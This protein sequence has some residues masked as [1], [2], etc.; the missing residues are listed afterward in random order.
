MEPVS[1]FFAHYYISLLISLAVIA[2]ALGT[3]WLIRRILF[4]LIGT[5]TKGTGSH[6]DVFL[7]D[8]LRAPLLIW[9]LML[10]LDLAVR[11]SEVPVKIADR[12][13]VALAIL[14]I[15]SLTLMMSRLAG[16]LV[17]FYGGRFAGDLPVT[18]LSK[19]LA[20]IFVIV[21]GGVSILHYLKI[22]VTPLLTALGVGGLAVA[23]ALQDTLSNLFG[24]LYMT[25]A[26][27]VRLGDYIRLNSGEEG[28]ITDISWRSTTIRGLTNNLVIIPNST[29]AKA[30]ITN[31]NLP[32]KRMA[33]T[34]PVGVDYSCDPD[35][36]EAVLLDV[37]R[38]AAADVPSI[39]TDPAPLVR[40]TPGFGDS[41]LQFT[42]ICHVTEF[43]EQF[44]VQH[45]LRKRILKRFRVEKIDMPFPTRT[46]F[47][48][49]GLV[50]E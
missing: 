19:N 38:K 20:Q 23:L 27:Q 18:S 31:F 33:L 35:V 34:I 6:L 4:R 36:V 3:G 49:Q 14:W 13:E 7:I 22:S 25:V 28:Y 48:K 8:S 1:R 9:F 50:Q 39:L 5:W 47:V 41:A 2:G 45:E 21:L 17:R 30:I 44:R 10:G 42:L 29:M 32:E 24:G 12:I 37:A 46:V 15:L 40:F 43:S 11:F 26:G 16:N